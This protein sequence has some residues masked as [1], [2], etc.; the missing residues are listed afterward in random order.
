[1]T[2]GHPDRLRRDRVHHR[3]HRLSTCARQQRVRRPVREGQAGGAEMSPLATGS[4]RPRPRRARRAADGRSWPPTPSRPAEKQATNWTAIGMFARLR[5]RARCSSP[6]GRPRKTKS[7]ADFYTA[8]GGITGFQNGLAIAGD[9]MSAASFLGISA[10]VM[11]SRLRRA[12]L[13]DRLP[14]RLAG[15][16]L[17]DGRAAAQPRQ[18]HLR[19]RG[20]ASASRRRRCASSPPPARWS[21]W[22]ST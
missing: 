4:G 13:L 11:V 14:G 7:A 8:G 16:H 2:L 20:R 3:H 12:D 21:S 19:R 5:R 22:P 17:P 9:Y 6:S 18:V 1:M 10:A 15:H